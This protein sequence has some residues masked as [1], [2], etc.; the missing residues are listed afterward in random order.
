MKKLFVFLSIA[1]LSMASCTKFDDSQIWD[2]LNN[3][4]DR[5]KT[6]ETWCKQVN[7]NIA[8]LQTALTALQNND[9]VTNVVEVTEGGVTVGYTLTFAKSGSVTIY[10]GK[11][12]EDGAPGK[13]G[14][15]GAPGVPGQDGQDGKD[16]HTPVVGVRKDTDGVYYWTLDGEWLLN[17]EG[18]K[19]PVT[20]KDGQD[21]A[22]GQN[23]E[24]GADGAQG[25]PGQD[26]S[27]GQPG[28]DGQD[29][30]D[31]EDGITPQLKIEDDYWYVSYD[32]GATWVRL[33]KAVG[34]DGKDGKDGKDGVSGDSFIK[35][36]DTSNA[37]YIIITLTDGTQMK[38]PTWKAFEDLQ[39]LVSRLNTNLTSLQAIV[40]ALQENDYVTNVSPVM[41]NGKEVGYTITFAKSGSITVYHGKDGNSEEA[42]VI[43][44]KE[45]VDGMY[46]WTVDGKWM[47]DEDGNKIP[48]TVHNG[49][50]GED[51]KDGADGKDGITPQ[52][53]IE[54]GY[55]YLS[56][57]NGFS[58]T[59]LGK[60]TGADGKDGQ[61]GEDGKDGQDGAPG[62]DGKDGDSMFQDINTSNPDY[63][64][65]T[66]ANGTQ[67]KLPTWKA[68]EAL[69]KL[70]NQ[71]NKNIEALQA[72]VNALQN[73]DYIT[74]ITPI[75]E[76]AE[77]IGYIIKFSKSGS[78]TI[79]HG[80]DGKDGQDGTDG[81]DGQDGEDGKDGQNG[82]DGAD[83]KDGETP[84]I[85]VQKDTD[86]VYYWTVNGKW[87]LDDN[88]QKVKAVGTDGK[89]G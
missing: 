25:R 85:G 79:Y 26:G 46:Y 44:V 47:L 14:Q 18:E 50:D 71:M 32:N 22:P 73:N 68:F 30:E 5:I 51:G 89:D 2:K 48:A 15:D 74:S 81:K 58:W 6:L 65:V 54:D 20:G 39:S 41:S 67:I 9:Y 31:G 36:V 53:K 88:G 70:C 57:D 62:K 23:G 55:W 42:P 3:H 29:G 56:T 8:S 84:V 52:L 35:K 11:D 59:Q 49:V 60:A 87:L 33:H 28:K 80:K 82:Q 86:G 83:G 16:G 19:I 34:E 38:F 12:G 75:Y 45:D 21:G 4:E 10:H 7:T 61:D 40:K 24:D 72:I 43:G 69:Q 1:V 76:G 64:L 63:V 37:E 78:V 66:L 77:E 27:D 13:D 17:D